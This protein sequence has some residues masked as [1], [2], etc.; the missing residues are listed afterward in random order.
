MQSNGEVLQDSHAPNASGQGSQHDQARD[1]KTLKLESIGKF[2]EPVTRSW[3]D[4]DVMLYALS[5]GYGSEDFQEDLQFTTENSEGHMPLM[6]CPTFA[7]A[8]G[9]NQEA[10]WLAFGPSPGQ[11]LL[12]SEYIDFHQPLGTSGHVTV[13]T[14]VDNI[15]DMGKHSLLSM[16]S[17][18][19][20]EASDQPVFARKWTVVLRD[21]GGWGGEA[22]PA[23]PQ[24]PSRAPDY[25]R[26]MA[27]HPH[28]ALLYRLV[29]SRSAIHSDPALARRSGFTAP[30]MHG[31]GTL[32]YAMQMLSKG[33]VSDV[34]RVTRIGAIFRRPAQPG[35]T[36]ALNAWSRDERSIEFTMVNSQGDTVLTG[37]VCEIGA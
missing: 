17:T 15:Y 12:A 26:E 19:R 23:L 33:P 34:R 4:A 5:V 7:T 30:I 2:G 10:E 32:G 24:A 6:V 3:T 16:F 18:A 11:T 1:P 22:P 21:T 8:A 37:G 36:V 13:N 14:K 20:D 31:R 27:L 29:D 9:R 28:S 35:E 25:T